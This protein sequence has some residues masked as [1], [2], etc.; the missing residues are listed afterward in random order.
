MNSLIDK[1]YTNDT[2]KGYF[3]TKYNKGEVSREEIVCW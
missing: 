1:V 2:V 3:P